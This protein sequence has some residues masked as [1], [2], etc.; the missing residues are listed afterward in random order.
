VD[1]NQYLPHGGNRI[2]QVAAELLQHIFGMMVKVEIV[3]KRVLQ[4]I[5]LATAATII[6]ISQ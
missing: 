5:H 6:L 3:K 1:Q 2:P 4:I